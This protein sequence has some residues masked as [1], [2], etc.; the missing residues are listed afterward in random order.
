[1]IVLLVSLCYVCLAGYCHKLKVALNDQVCS[2]NFLSKDNILPNNYSTMSWWRQA[3][4]QWDDDDVRFVLD[5]DAYSCVFIVLTHWNNWPH[6][7]QVWKWGFSG[8][9]N[10]IHVYYT[11]NN[12]QDSIGFVM[13]TVM[14]GENG[15]YERRSD[16]TKD[17]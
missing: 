8:N 10:C 6:A 3:T 9:H 15:G 12:Q 13:M 11:N 17:Y 7:C 14:N 5:H 2:R 4:F 1:L 16:Q